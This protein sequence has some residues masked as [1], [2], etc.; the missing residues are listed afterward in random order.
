MEHSMS[1]FE[2]AVYIGVYAVILFS[3][4]VFINNQQKRIEQ[5]EAEEAANAHYANENFSEQP[6]LGSGL[7]R[8]APRQSF[9]S[10]SSQ[11]KAS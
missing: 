4:L 2:I 11:R 6:Q 5:A 1:F 7:G 10:L 9:V 3:G 8:I